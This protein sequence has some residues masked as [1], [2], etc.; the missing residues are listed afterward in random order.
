MVKCSLLERCIH[1]FRGGLQ[2][3]TR[4][5]LYKAPVNLK[6]TDLCVD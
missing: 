6:P 5:T 1:S 2:T 4:N 3:L